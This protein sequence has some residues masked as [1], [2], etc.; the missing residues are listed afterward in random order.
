MTGMCVRVSFCGKVAIPV[1]HSKQGSVCKNITTRKS[2]NIC[3]MV[4]VGFFFFLLTTIYL[5]TV[6]FR[7]YCSLTDTTLSS[8]ISSSE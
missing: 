2:Q 1:H 5:N 8:Q 6:S 4:F 7:D 3:V